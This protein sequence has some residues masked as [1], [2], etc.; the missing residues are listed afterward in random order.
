MVVVRSLGKSG[1]AA[2]PIRSRRD[3]A[4]AKAVAQR[5]ADG[6]TRDASAEA[7]LQSL[8]HEMERFDETGDE[9]DEALPG[10]G[11][12]GGPHRRWSDDAAGE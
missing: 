1:R 11:D 9:L 2:R 12:Y 3:L 5:L 4:G 7:R 10:D 6:G 8:L